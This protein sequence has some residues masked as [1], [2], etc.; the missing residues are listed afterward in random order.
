MV[1]QCRIIYKT[2]DWN[3]FQCF[4]DYIF[5]PNDRGGEREAKED[6]TSF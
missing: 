5:R 6:N 3:D 1:M 4:L 2:K